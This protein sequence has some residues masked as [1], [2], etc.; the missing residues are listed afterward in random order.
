MKISELLDESFFSSKGYRVSPSWITL[1]PLTDSNF[2]GFGGDWPKD[3]GLSVGA[4]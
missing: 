2:N 4:N 3:S 1:M